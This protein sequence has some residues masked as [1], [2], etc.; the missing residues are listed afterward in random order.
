MLISIRCRCY[1]KYRQNSKQPMTREIGNYD[2]EFILSISSISFIST[3]TDEPGQLTIIH[4]VDKW[5]SIVV[6]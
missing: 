4:E 3:H 5:G 2:I 1:R 6:T